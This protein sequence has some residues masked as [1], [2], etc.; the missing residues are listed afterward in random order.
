[1]EG[2]QYFVYG[3]G[4]ALVDV[5][6]TISEEGLAA[7]GFKKGGR[8]TIDHATFLSLQKYT[9]KE[10]TNIGAGGST[11]NTLATLATLGHKVYLSCQLANDVWGKFYARDLKLREIDAPKPE[12][13]ATHRTGACITFV[14]PDGERT[15]R[16]YLGISGQFQTPHFTESHL[17]RSEFLFMEGYFLTEP[18]TQEFLHQ[19]RTFIQNT[20]VKTVF[21]LSDPGVVDVFHKTFVEFLKTP[22]DLLFANEPEAFSLCQSRKCEDVVKMMKQYA[23]QFVIT[24]S[25]RGALL[26]DGEKQI[27]IP[28]LKVNVINKLGAGD[29]FAGAFLHALKQE[30]S[31]EDAGRFAAEIAAKVVSKHGARLTD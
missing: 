7:L 21:S 20:A 2:M 14:T 3:I 17:H 10:P 6:Y 5:E 19:A 1:M 23:K 16:T 27:Q 25:E 9:E 4:H 18:Q 8:E 28:A 15:M 22:V 31:F 30:E 11:A 13:S 12:S 26:F 24:Q 29:C